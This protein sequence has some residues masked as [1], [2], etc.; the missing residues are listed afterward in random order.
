MQAHKIATKLMVLL[1]GRNPKDLGRAI[2]GYKLLNN[3]VI[4]PF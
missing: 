4:D 2:Y 1:E 3:Q